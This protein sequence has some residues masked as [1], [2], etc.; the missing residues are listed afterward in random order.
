[1]LVSLIREVLWLLQLGGD[2]GV[3]WGIISFGPLEV[4][5]GSQVYRHYEALFV[6]SI[7]SRDLVTIRYSLRLYGVL[8]V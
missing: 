6:T 3:T 2:V 7:C 5:V 8:P 4:L 1:M